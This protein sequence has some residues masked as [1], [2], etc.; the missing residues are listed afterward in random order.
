MSKV[1]SKE[2]TSSNWSA[3][4]SLYECVIQNQGLYPYVFLED[5]TIE[6]KV[7]ATTT[8]GMAG[9]ELFTGINHDPKKYHPQIIALRPNIGQANVIACVKFFA[10]GI[11]A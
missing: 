8:W 10:T 4:G 6:A 3:W 1:F 11:L 2:V 9:I 5:P 7:V